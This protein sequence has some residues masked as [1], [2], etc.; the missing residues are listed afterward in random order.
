MNWECVEAFIKRVML[1]KGKMHERKLTKARTTCTIN[2]CNGE[3]I[4][5]IL[6]NRRSPFG[7]IHARC[8]KCNLSM[9]E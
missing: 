6:P 4:A 1:L 5:R 9:I 3:I 7:H 8:K 2:G